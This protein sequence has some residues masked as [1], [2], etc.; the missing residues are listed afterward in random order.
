MKNGKKCK[1][2]GSKLD[3]KEDIKH[4]KSL[5]HSAFN[6][7]ASIL[8]STKTSKNY[9]IR[10]FSAFIESIFLY[11][12]ELWGLTKKDEGEIDILQRNFLRKMFN[13][14]FTEARDNWPSNLELYKATNQVPWSETIEKRRLSFF[15]HVCRLSDDT[16]AKK[17]L[18]EALN[19][20]SRPRG[21]SKTSYLDTVKKDLKKC[22]I[23]SIEEAIQIAQNRVLWKIKTMDK[24]SGRQTQ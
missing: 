7:W 20:V 19:P 1:L 23:K 9:K 3:S 6:K 18:K 2:V 24:V 15:G 17:A 12:S 16:P 22:N 14:R 5:A 11:N 10:L 8:C 4:R 21:R 13:Y